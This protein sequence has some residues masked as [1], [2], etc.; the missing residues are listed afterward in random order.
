MNVTSGKTWAPVLPMPNTNKALSHEV[1]FQAN[2]SDYFNDHPFTIFWLN[3]LVMRLLGPDAYSARVLTAAFSV[4]SVFLLY[5]IGALLY[6]EIY[7]LL[8]A[9]F[10]IF[11]RDFILTSGT[12][13]LDTA[14]VFFILATFYF[15]LKKNWIALGVFA[16]IGLWVK[17]PMVLLVFPTA[18]FFSLLTDNSKVFRKETGKLFLAGLL[19]LVVGSLV[20]LYTGC[21]AGWEVVQDYWVRQLWGTA[22]GGR[23]GPADRSFSFFFYT[24]KT[25]FLPGLPFLFLAFY[26]IYLKR[27]VKK[28]FILIPL[29]ATMM[30]GTVVSLMSFKLGHY[31]TP[32]FPF[33]ALLAAYSIVGWVEQR[34]ARFCR[35]IQVATPLFFCFFL[36][37]PAELAPEAFIALTKFESF[38]Q[39]HGTCQDT[40]Y[41]VPGEEPVGSSL[42]YTLHLE[43]YT[44]RIVKVVQCS[45]LE[46]T[47]KQSPPSWLILGEENFK[48]CLSLSAQE[49]AGSRVRMGNLLLVSHLL[50]TRE[51][52]LT[53]LLLERQ[54]VIDCKPPP[55]PKDRWHRYSVDARL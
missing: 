10:L 53:P 3:G 34:A 22:V 26:R 21:V 46:R 41:L 47:M 49:A 54:A 2:S 40:V 42:D 44:G 36:V 16:G 32:I 12:F 31:Y 5:L 45:D 18:F 17:T 30:V 24:V 50:A 25:G 7:G 28:P 43:F 37:S 39:T 35:A 38:I 19:A 52:D 8:A 29:I 15:W 55:Y 4:G 48:N 1:G 23:G 13:S 9:L 14:L 27:A 11:T 6:S 51:F 33:L 20:W